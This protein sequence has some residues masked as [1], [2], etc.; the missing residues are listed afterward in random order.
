M[1]ASEKTDILKGNFYFSV[2]ENTKAIKFYVTKTVDMYFSMGIYDSKGR[3]RGQ[4]LHGGQES[5]II[6]EI[7]ENS[8]P[9]T[10]SGEIPTGEWYCSVIGEGDE[11]LPKQ[12][13][14]QIHIKW[15]PKNV[16]PLNYTAWVDV[17]NYPKLS[18]FDGDKIYD[19]QVK[20]YKGDLHTHTHYS[21]GAMSPEQIIQSA[22]EQDLDF[23]VNTDHNIMTTAWPEDNEILVIPGIEV[24]FYHGHSNIINPY[25]L[26]YQDGTIGEI[27][28]QKGAVSVFNSDFG[29][30][31]LKTI[32]H[33]VLGQHTWQYG[34]IPIA[35]IDAIEIINGPNHPKSIANDWAMLIWDYLLNDGYKITGIG[36]SDVHAAP[37]STHESLIGN[38]TNYIHSEKLTA[39]ALVR[40]IK[41]G[42]VIVS[43]FGS[44][45]LNFGNYLPG[46]T[47]AQREGEISLEIETDKPLKVEWVLDGKIVQVNYNEISS[48]QFYLDKKYHWLR[49]NFRYLDGRLAGFTNPYYF[50][51]KTPTVKDWQAVIEYINDIVPE[52]KNFYFEDY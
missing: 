11:Y 12:E 10:I 4:F 16:Q 15:N 40:H 14:G 36:G 42:H 25:H 19:S 27:A 17:N 32:N 7:S 33:P 41:A 3:L 47:V 39:N 29:N 23:F 52:T 30:D 31:S 38:P 22:K 50:G 13:W 6:S 2:P 45:H 5:F 24:S 1:K 44:V 35:K 26:A 20:W 43:R 28:S 51:N 49:L 46:D 8:S 9:Y 18:E 37:D 48:Y 21:D 34:R